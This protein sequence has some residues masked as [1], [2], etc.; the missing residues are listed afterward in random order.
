MNQATTVNTHTPRVLGLADGAVPRGT[1]VFAEDVP[2][3]AN[4][5]PALRRALRR[6][7]KAAAE[8][9]VELFVNSGW[10]TPAYQAR[11]LREAVERYGSAREAARWVSTPD[12]SAH[13]AGDA[14]DIGPRESAAWLAEHGAAYGLCRIYA[15]EPWHFELRPEAAVHGPPPMYADPSQDP[16]NMR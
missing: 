7:A 3:V 12:R 9:G 14:V 16:R 15:N 13:V 4:L 1:T 2:G 8:D 11:L 5:A 10:R 6:A